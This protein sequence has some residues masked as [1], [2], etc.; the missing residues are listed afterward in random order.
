MQEQARCGAAD[1]AVGDADVAD[2]AGRVGQ[3][4]PEPGVL[5][6]AAG[7]GGDGVGATV[8]IRVLHR[9]QRRVIDDGG[10]HAAFGQKACQGAADRTRPHHAHIHLLHVH[11]STR[12]PLCHNVG[13]DR[14]S[15]PAIRAAC[16]AQILGKSFG[17]SSSLRNQPSLARGTVLDRRFGM[18]SSRHPIWVRSAGRT[19]A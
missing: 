19:E 6:H 11:H 18:R 9:R 3:T 12:G 8:E 1:L 17:R 15:Q 7:A 14:T 2:R 13:Q 16:A 5:Q 10:A 4:V